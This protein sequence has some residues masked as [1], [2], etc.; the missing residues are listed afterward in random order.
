MMAISVVLHILAL[1]LEIM[2]LALFIRFVTFAIGCVVRLS[3]RQSPRFDFGVFVLIE[4]R[5]ELL[6][7]RNFDYIYIRLH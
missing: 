6:R 7:I 5:D 1:E 2:A 3:V 4:W